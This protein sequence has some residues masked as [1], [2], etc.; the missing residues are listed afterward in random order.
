MPTLIVYGISVSVGT[1]EL[2]KLIP[3]LQ[4]MVD[5]TSGLGVKANDVSVFIPTDRVSKGLG[6]EIIILICGLEK[7]PQTTSAV[8]RELAGRVGGGTKHFFKDALV[9]VYIQPMDKELC[10]SSKNEQNNK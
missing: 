3:H 7:K 2:E 4:L 8:L 9:E 5:G 6:E 10:W 1:G